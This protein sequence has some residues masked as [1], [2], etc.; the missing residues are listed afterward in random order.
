MFSRE[1]LKGFEKGCYWFIDQHV[2]RQVMKDWK[3]LGNTYGEIPYEWN[4]WGIKKNNIF[5]TGK[6]NKKDGIRFKQA[7]LRWLPQHWYD[8]IVVEIRNTDT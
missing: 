1:L 8:K 6:G 7:Q 3:N 4:S 2:L 5:S